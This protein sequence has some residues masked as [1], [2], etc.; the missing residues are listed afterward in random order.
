MNVLDEFT[1]VEIALFDKLF[2]EGGSFI[3]LQKFSTS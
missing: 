3:L 1:R 2:R